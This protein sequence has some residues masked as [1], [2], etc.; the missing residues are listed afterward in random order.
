MESIAENP[1]ENSQAPAPR[2]RRSSKEERERED[3]LAR[4]ERDRMAEQG[5]NR[6]LLFIALMLPA[7]LWVASMGDRMNT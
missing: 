3:E 6:V 1:L 7:L 2:E 5:L 4:L